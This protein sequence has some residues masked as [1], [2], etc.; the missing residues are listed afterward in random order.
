MKYRVV[1]WHGMDKND[2]AYHGT[3]CYDFER[4]Y[5][6]ADGYDMLEEIDRLLHVCKLNVCILRPYEDNGV[7]TIGFTKHRSFG[8]R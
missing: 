3:E 8:M 4:I 6:S 2:P 1:P 7:Y 5:D